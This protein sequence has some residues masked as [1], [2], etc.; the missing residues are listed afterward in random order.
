MYD[1]ET[2][3]VRGLVRKAVRLPVPVAWAQTR[4]WTVYLQN[5][6]YSLKL[7]F[8]Q[9]FQEIISGLTLAGFLERKLSTCFIG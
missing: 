1:C 7:C 4:S 9:D 2:L 5:Q 8:L 6:C 3:S